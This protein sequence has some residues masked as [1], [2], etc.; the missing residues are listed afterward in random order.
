MKE[1][2]SV[3]GFLAVLCC[4][5][6]I[7]FAQES[8]SYK[9]SRGNT[10][11]FA[12]GDISFADRV[13]SFN[14]GV[15]GA[16]ASKSQPDQ[17]LG[18]PNFD[19]AKDKNYVTLGCAGKLTLEFMDNVLVDGAGDDLYVYEIGPDIEPTKV[20]ISKDGLKWIDVG[21]VKGSTASLDI[22]SYVSSGDEF[23]FVRLTDLKTACRAGFPGAD[24]DAVGAI[25]AKRSSADR[26]INTTESKTY[27]DSRGV[28]TRY[29]IGDLSFADAVV[30][31]EKGIPAAALRNSDPSESLGRPNYSRAN[32]DKNYV[33]LGCG[34]K[35]TV[36]FIDNILIDGPGNDLYVYEIGPDVEPTQVE[37][38]IDGKD[39]IR[40]GSVRGSTASLD[41]GKFVSPLDEFRFVRLTDLRTACG[42]GYPGA[43]IDAVG[44][45]S[46]RRN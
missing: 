7:I 41:I 17:A 20:E 14:K 15:P 1:I 3:F 28:S 36:E 31:F 5:G 6:G 22:K 11:R 18:R 43:D 35:L 16:S 32:E 21:K 4:F 9:D 10:G 39:W 25:S 42:A 26:K 44:A 37:I 29:G 27:S 33:T 38:S 8:T 19:Q 40:V 34:G 30:S 46:S 23:S 12:L 13:V 2:G 24:I 45:I